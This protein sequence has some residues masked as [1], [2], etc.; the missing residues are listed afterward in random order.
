MAAIGYIDP[1]S[2]TMDPNLIEAAITPREMSGRGSDPGGF[3][4]WLRRQVI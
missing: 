3:R 1:V 2:F 4:E